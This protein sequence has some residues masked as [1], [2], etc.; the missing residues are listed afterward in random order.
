MTMAYEK[1]TLTIDPFT[2]MFEGK[3]MQDKF[4]DLKMSISFS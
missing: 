1:A 3:R 4:V 2:R